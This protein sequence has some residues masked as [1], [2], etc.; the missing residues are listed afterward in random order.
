MNSSLK[1]I[2]FVADEGAIRIMLSAILLRYGF[3]V[4]VAATVAE[5]I[6]EIGSQE[7]DLMLC[8][9]SA[10]LRRSWK[11]VKIRRSFEAEGHHRLDPGGS[12][13]GQNGRKKC[14]E[15]KDSRGRGEDGRIP[16]L[17]TV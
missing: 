17:D 3:S 5:A 7:F 14:G 15:T 13:R 9:R 1:R 8:D 11:G 16:G 6:D 4:I 12:L 2:L 10:Q